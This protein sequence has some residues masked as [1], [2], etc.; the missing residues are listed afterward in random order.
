MA[1]IGTAGHVDHGKST[2]I[3]ALTGRD[4]DRWA[5]EK[6]RGLTIDLGFAWTTLGETE[7]SFVDVP[8]HERFI[9][10]MLAG[11]E[12]ID[13]VL[14]VVAADEG[15][16]P[17]SEEHLAVVDLLGVTSGVI[18]LTKIDAVDDDLLELAQLEIE[19]H[20]AGT[21]LAGMSIIGVSATEGTGLDTLKAELERIAS[22]ID[23]NRSYDAPPKLWIDRSFSVSGAGTVV[24][25]TLAAGSLT[26]G[27]SVELW[28]SGE[29]ARIRTLH[30][31]DQE[32][33]TVRA[34]SRCAV[35]LSG[36]ERVEVGRGNLLTAPG[37]V[38][39]TAVFLANIDA[40]RYV[41]DLTPRGAYHL[42]LGT[43]AWP[44]QLRSIPGTDI[45]GGAAILKLQ[46]PL[47]VTV[48]ERFILREV[49]RRSVVGG[50]TIVVPGADPRPS[51]NQKFVAAARSLPDLG[52]DEV[53]THLLSMFG[54]ASLA[55]ILVWSNGGSPSGAIVAGDIAIT[56]EQGNAISVRIT[57]LVRQFHVDNP[58]REGFPKASLASKL[59]VNLAVVETVLS[60]N[61]SLRDDGSTVALT[62]FNAKL[63][64]A[65]EDRWAS[66]R[67]ELKASGLAV[68]R[69]A[70]LGVDQEMLHV[71]L[72]EARLTRI[73]G[74]LV[75]LPDQVAQIID[76][77][78]ELGS[79]F[80][81]AEFRDALGL[82]RK[83]AVPI[84]EYLDG[85]GITMRA[86]DNRSL[87]G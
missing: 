7:M 44:V 56:K 26:V 84:L 39:P 6:A 20:L 32:E 69:L 64:D 48:G 31:H 83:Y 59:N 82:S 23:A 17:Q 33:E 62:S 10:N 18:A 77:V 40:A 71:L 27:D 12:M 37:H 60:D 58:L 5:E 79:G 66:V 41:E 21:A 47:P 50:G 76:R 74:D 16:M 52:P 42:H 65:Q 30:R 49:G 87:R 68:P 51:H 72:R 2:L 75:Y 15:W 3:A 81:V 55:D 19:E 54:T 29:T 67:E 24:T 78:G 8:G 11:S 36:I 61:D 80:T 53:A 85:Q 86:G 70:D 38:R 35:N 22:E 25:G 14:F 43:G 28:P 57:S 4:P 63:T 13:A 45:S 73:S 34:G 46:Q 9:K 1:V